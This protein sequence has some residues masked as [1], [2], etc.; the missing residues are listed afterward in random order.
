MIE[1]LYRQ[2]INPGELVFDIGA[3]TGSR[4]KVFMGLGARVVAVEPR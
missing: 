1:N 4:S 3:N 2:F